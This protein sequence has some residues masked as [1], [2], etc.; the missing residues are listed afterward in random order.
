[1]FEYLIFLDERGV[2]IDIVNQI[3]VLKTVSLF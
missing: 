2:F 1:M 3:M